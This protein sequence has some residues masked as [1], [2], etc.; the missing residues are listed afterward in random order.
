VFPSKKAL[1][2]R[3]PLLAMLLEE[4]RVFNTHYVALLRRH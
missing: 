4:L 1:A 3:L 2:A